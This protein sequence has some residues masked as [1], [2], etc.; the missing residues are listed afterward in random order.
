M[1]IAPANAGPAAM[2]TVLGT[3]VHWPRFRTQAS[4]SPSGTLEQARAAAG[5][6]AP[7]ADSVAKPSSILYLGPAEP[8]RCG[9]SVVEHSLGKGLD[10]LI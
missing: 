2:V 10:L 3:D 9:S 8:A 6:P 1:V 7:E 4:R 5:S